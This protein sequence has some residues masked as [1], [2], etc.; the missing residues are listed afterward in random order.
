MEKKV[1]VCSMADLFGDWVPDY[2][3]MSIIEAIS[4]WSVVHNQAERPIFQFLT[5]NPK[6]YAEF[7]YPDNCWLGTTVESEVQTHRI[8]DLIAST[9]GKNV[10]FVSFEPLLGEV[11]HP[12]E[13]IDWIIIGAQTGPGAKRVDEDVVDALFENAN[14][15][16]IPIF[17]KDNLGYDHPMRR[18]PCPEDLGRGVV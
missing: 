4:D 12:L 13:G 9:P 8:D 3:I 15:Y 1:F 14:L 11:K 10:R 18:F 7:D 6:R 17:V 5:K 2:W 16:D